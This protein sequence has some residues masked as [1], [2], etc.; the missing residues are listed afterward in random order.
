MDVRLVFTVS[1]HAA[2]QDVAGAPQHSAAKGVFQPERHVTESAGEG[3]DD[4]RDRQHQR[5][6][7]EQRPG[8]PGQGDVAGGHVGGLV[9]EHG[10]VADPSR[11]PKR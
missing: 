5:Q 1:H 2:G 3:G 9:P 7:P 8:Q 6:R 11:R 10:V 4:Q